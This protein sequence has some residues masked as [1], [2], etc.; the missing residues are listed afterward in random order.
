MRKILNR[1]N[2]HTCLN[3]RFGSALYAI[4]ILG[5]NAI[6]KIF[7]GHTV[8]KIS[9]TEGYFTFLRLEGKFRVKDFFSTSNLKIHS[10]MSL[11]LC[12]ILWKWPQINAFLPRINMEYKS[13]VGF[14]LDANLS[15]RNVCI[16]IESNWLTRSTKWRLC[17]SQLTQASYLQKN[18]MLQI[19]F[20]L[21]SL[22]LR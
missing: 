13:L 7:L 8:T 6:F 2:I 20:F 17:V 15:S 14:K 21:I 19:F 4:S 3:E 18:Q 9:P 12:Q 16:G 22:T 5:R 1:Q 11:D 10:R